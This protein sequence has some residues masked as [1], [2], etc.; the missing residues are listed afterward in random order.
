MKKAIGT[1]PQ[2]KCQFKPG[3]AARV[4]AFEEEEGLEYVQEVVNRKVAE[5]H[6]SRGLIISVLNSLPCSTSFAA[7][8]SRTKTN[9][10]KSKTMA[11]L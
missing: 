5:G 10:K 1:D 11:K 7:K 9:Q 4:A 3:E 2:G 6:K 8:D